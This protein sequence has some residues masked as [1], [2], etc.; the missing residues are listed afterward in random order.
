MINEGFEPVAAGAP[1]VV[2]G[3]GHPREGAVVGE[4]AGLL[5][6]PVHAALAVCGIGAV[7]ARNVFIQ[8]EGMIEDSLK[9]FGAVRW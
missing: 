5:M 9:A 3:A 8:V 7:A 4:D 1:D 2:G 6:S